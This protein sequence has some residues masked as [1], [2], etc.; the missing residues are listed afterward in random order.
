MNKT[1]LMIVFSCLMA[2]QIG[3]EEAT[4]TRLERSEFLKTSSAR[5]TTVVP[6]EKLGRVSEKA[7]K[8]QETKGDADWIDFTDAVSQAASVSE[9]RSDV[10]ISTSRGPG[11]SIRYQTLGER[12]RGMPPTTAKGLT[13]LRERMLIGAY[14]IWSERKGTSTSSKDS[15]FQIVQKKENLALEELQ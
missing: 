2:N 11:A 9:V 12:K 8:W 5:L 6:S 1:I 10:E 3:A 13:T 7:V 15:Q 14:Y 4:V